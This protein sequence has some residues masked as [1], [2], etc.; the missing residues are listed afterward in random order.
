MKRKAP[1]T[2]VRKNEGEILF[3]ECLRLAG[4]VDFEFEKEFPGSPQKPDYSFTHE[5]SV[6]LFDVKDFVPQ[7]GD[8][9]VCGPFDP[10]VDI[11]KKI[12]EG[13]RKFKNLKT[14]PCALDEEIR[15]P[16]SI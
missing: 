9:G 16:I 15:V 13:R 10:Y 2:S 1:K 6:L 5:G 4:I 14:Y 11:R 12:E 3:E 8:F 7:A